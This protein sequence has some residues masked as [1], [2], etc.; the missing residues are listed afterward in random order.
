M[1]KQKEA[2]KN[3]FH[4]VTREN[5]FILSDSSKEFLD[6]F[7]CQLDDFVYRLNFD[8]ELYRAQIGCKISLNDNYKKPFD[9]DRMYPLI[10][11]AR[12]GRANPKGIPFLY[13]ATEEET[14]IG[15]IRPWIGNFVSVAIMRPEKDLLLVDFTRKKTIS[16][17]KIQNNNGNVVTDYIV[18][19]AINNEFAKPVTRS[20]NVA[21]YIPTQILAEVV[22]SEGFD[23]IKYKSSLGK[24]DNIALFS[25]KSLIIDDVELYE[26]TKLEHSYD[27]AY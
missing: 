19:G 7:R 15:E 8:D 16:E 1:F 14:A 12:E 11:K 2:F 27:L 21:E 4:E 22:K 5:R 9:P 26:I 23:G 10:D 17:L 13:V 20:D 25:P 24:G 6:D 3:Y 18:W